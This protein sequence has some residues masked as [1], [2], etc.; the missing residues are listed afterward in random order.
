MWIDFPDELKD[1]CR[2]LAELSCLESTFSYTDYHYGV[3]SQEGT[4]SHLELLNNFFEDT[5]I[6]HDNLCDFKIGRPPYL[7]DLKEGAYLFWG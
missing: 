5:S 6:I 4:T 3:A 7:P 2:K 1:G